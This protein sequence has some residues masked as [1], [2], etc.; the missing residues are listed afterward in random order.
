MITQT[1]ASYIIPIINGEIDKTL[2]MV[3]DMESG[4]TSLTF[5]AREIGIKTGN[6]HIKT[7]REIID[8]MEC[9]WNS[10]AAY[11]IDKLVTEMQK[12]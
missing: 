4:N 3:H 6:V 2:E 11:T 10:D 5:Q 7:L 1:Q 8:A 9:N 12:L